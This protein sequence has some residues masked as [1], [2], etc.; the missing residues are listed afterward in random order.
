VKTRRARRTLLASLGILVGVLFLA[1][2]CDLGADT[3]NPPVKITSTN[4]NGVAPGTLVTISVDAQSPPNATAS[5][6]YG[7][8]AR[9]C[10]A[11]VPILNSADF[12]PTQGGNCIAHPLS[13][14]TSALTSVGIDPPY[15]TGTLTY[16]LGAGTDHYTMGDGTA[17]TITCNKA[18]P[19]QLVTKVQVPASTAIP[20]GQVY[21]HFPVAFSS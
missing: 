10:K 14:G 16:K 3:A 6:V 15:K 5:A 13:A 21:K 20:S 9:L 2:A 1:A 11:N 7:I 18:T 12:A 19:C 4:V 8:E 17:V